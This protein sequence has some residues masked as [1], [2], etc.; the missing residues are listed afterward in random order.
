MARCICWGMITIHPK[1][2]PK[3]GSYKPRLYKIWA[4]HWK[5]PI[6]FMS[7]DIRNHIQQTLAIDPARYSLKV[8]EN[9]VASFGYALAGCLHMLRYA[10]NVRIQLLATLFVGG[11]GLWLG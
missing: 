10:K 1:I 9:R 2:K 3:C 7:K 6:T 5:C 8:S 4:L 11:V